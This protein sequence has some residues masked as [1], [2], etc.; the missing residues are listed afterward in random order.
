MAKLK[1]LKLDD[2]RAFHRDFYGTANGE[3]ASVGDFDADAVKKQLEALFAEWKSP[4]PYAPISTKFTDVAAKQD[5][6]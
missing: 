5:V 3:I 2:V 1:A 6:Q 4:K